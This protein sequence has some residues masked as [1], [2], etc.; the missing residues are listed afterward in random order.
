MVD[1]TDSRICQ[2]AAHIEAHATSALYLSSLAE[3]AAM[4][5]FHFQRRFKEVM[6]VTP[7]QF[8]NALRIQRLKQSLRQGQDV[9]GAIYDAGFGSTSRVYEQLP[10]RIGVTPS[11]LR[12][13]GMDLQIH[14]ALRQT[15]F[16]HIL[17]AATERGVCFVQF[18]DGFTDLLRE[19][20]REFPAAE[21]IPTPKQMDSELDK[22][23]RALERHLREGGPQPQVPLEL[24]GTAFQ[25]KI[26]KFL[27]RI[28]SGERRTYK[29]VAQG[30]GAPASH[31]AVANACGANRIGVLVPCHRVLRGDG[32]LGGYRWGTDRKGRLLEIEAASP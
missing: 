6:G 26:W 16:G 17:M 12:A 20:H 7:K 32:G 4:S 1:T 19:L 14:F 24:F 25:I 5:P 9:L 21:L 29:Q 23:M 28:P 22:W 27:T 11:A 2:V 8:Q 18:G 31:R 3:R 13:G 15:S 30:I 10:N